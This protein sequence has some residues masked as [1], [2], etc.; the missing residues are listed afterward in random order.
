MNE[1]L[2][3][4]ISAEIDKLR[5]EL[6]KGQKELKKLEKQGGQSGSKLGTALKAAGKAVGTAMKAMVAATAAAGAALVG[7][8]EATREYRT[9]QAMLATAFQTS[10]GSAEMAKET[11]ND[12]YRVLGDSGKATEA[13]QHLAR[14]TT[15][16]EALSE[17]TT[18]CQG[19]YATFGDSLPIESLAEASNETAK[20]GELTGALADALNWAGIS[21]EEFKDQLF[22]CN[23]EA[24]REALI[25]STLTGLY[26]D[27]AASYEETAA[28]ILEANEAQAALTEG[29]AAAGAAVEPIITLFKQWAAT[30]LTDLVPSFSLVTEGLNEVIQGVEGGE[31]KMEEG[32]QGLVDSI[33]QT[34]TNALPK[35]LKTGTQIL[36]A[37]IKG[38]VEVFPDVIATVQELLPMVIETLGELIPMITGALLE[39]LPQIIDTIF[40]AAAQILQTLGEIIPEILSQIIAILPAVID[41]IVE[42]IPMLLQAAI[43]FLMAI[44]EA[45]PIIIP[46]LVAALPQIIESILNGVLEAIPVIIEG[47]IALF[48]GIVEAIPLI[49]PAIIEAIPQI[50]DSIIDFLISAI[51]MLIEGAIQL[52]MAIVDAIPEIIPALLQALPQI[53]QAVITGLV[54]R[55]DDLFFGIWDT[56]VGIFF[57]ADSSFGEWFGKCFEAVKSV[58]SGIGDFFRGVWDT[59]KSIFTGIAETIGNIISGVVKKAINAVLGVAVKIINGF[60]DAINFAISIINAIPGVNI[61]KLNKLEVPQMARGGIVDEATLAVIGERGK[62][63]VVPLEN[64]TEWMDILA[65]RLGGKMAGDG[66]PIY[67]MIDGTVFAKTT[68]KSINQLTKQTGKLDLVLA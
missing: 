63:A 67:L 13:A 52:F 23:T 48:N 49:I 5:Q 34:L 17:W 68:L 44:V 9:Q 41:S 62:E 35:V 25:R 20:T 57:G 24:E 37:L 65:E 39:G 15:E 22:L 18:I 12:L 16:E 3:I 1:E 38:I 64:N 19:V 6:Q 42:N 50:I 28:S 4:I 66:T 33:L 2:R 59:I 58:F 29:L 21:E 60:I 36:K 51:P 56:I 32:I 45:I 27:A 10:G 11:Y 61:N 46:E 53:V 54:T 47:A 55:L 30:A 8:S 7:L 26:G 31:A 14:L 40:E 43:D